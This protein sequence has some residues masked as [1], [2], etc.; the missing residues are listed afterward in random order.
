[1]REIEVKS[2]DEYKRADALCTE[3]YGE[4]IS[5][6]ITRME[7]TAYDVSRLVPSWKDEYYTLK[8]LR[9]LRNRIT[10]DPGDSECNESDLEAIAAF[11]TRLKSGGDPIAKA[12]RRKAEV[13]KRQAASEETE[14]ETGSWLFTLFVIAIIAGVIILLTKNGV[15]SGIFN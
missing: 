12:E 5:A 11:R 4:G 3:N 13:N 10:H 14:T 7:E 6:Y 9:W 15:C 1:M 8:R 2:L